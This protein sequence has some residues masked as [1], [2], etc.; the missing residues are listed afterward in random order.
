MPRVLLTG[1]NGFVGKILT[2][3]LR[4]AGYHVTA[5]SSSEPQLGHPA[6]QQRVCDIRDAEGVRQAVAQVRPSHVIHLAAV[7]H[8]PTSF[9]DPLGTWQTNVMGSMN[10]LEALRLEA[11]E[12]FVLFSSSSEV[13]GAAFKSG[14][15]V[16]EY[17]R[18]QPLNPYAASKVAAESAFNEY[19]RQGLKGVIAR[20][21]NH[22]G[23]QQSPN[24][25]TAS[26]SR[27][28]ALIEAGQQEPV[29]KVGNLEA[30]RDFLDVQD[31]CSAYLELLKLADSTQEY[32]RCMNIASGRSL[33][34]REVL[35]TLLSLSQASIQVAQDPERLRPSDIPVA[36][37]NSTALTRSTGWQPQIPLQ[38][39][40]RELLDYWRQQT[41]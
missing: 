39:T 9:Q 23:A 11:P 17:T 8:V 41:V 33:K 29:L 3:R 25:V 10:L 2:Q 27:Q 26:F 32:P 15:E 1:A 4:D 13:Y 20:P 28:I 14:Q 30:K 16:D 38:Q 34:I 5:L 18:C 40:L 21:F 6:D 12:A 37:G 22:I 24:F 36:I 19:F 31:V 35:D 7:S